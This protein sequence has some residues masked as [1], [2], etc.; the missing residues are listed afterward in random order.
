MTFGRIID[1]VKYIHL[2]NDNELK[3]KSLY[4]NVYFTLRDIFANAHSADIC[5][6]SNSFNSHLTD[7][8]CFED[9]TE[10]FQYSNKLHQK[11]YL[12]HLLR[13][14]EYFNVQYFEF[15]E[16]QEDE[17]IDMKEYMKWDDWWL[18]FEELRILLDE[19]YEKCLSEAKRCEE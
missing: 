9:R 13:W 18:Q 3:K 14:L 6:K 10:I 19:Q 1:S 11:D 4:D 5:M 12:K 8:I 15:E 16:P 17:E 7:G 2:M